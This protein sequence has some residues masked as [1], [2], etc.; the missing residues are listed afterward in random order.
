MKSNNYRN[1][2]YRLLAKY[3]QV[4]HYAKKAKI[5]IIRLHNSY[6]RLKQHY[7]KTLQ[8]AA[9]NTKTLLEQ[10]IKEK[11]PLI[12]DHRRR[13]VYISG[14]LLDAMEMTKEEFASSFYIDL[15]FEKYLPNN[16]TTTDELAI[17]EFHFPI[18]LQDMT[19]LGITTEQTASGSDM[20]LHPFLHLGISGKRVYNKRKKLFYYFLATRDMSA[21]IELL[22]Y[23]KSDFF[24]ETLSA[25]NLQLL[26]A[27]KTIEAHKMM[28][29]SLVCSLVEEH[30]RETSQHLQN[31]RIITTYIIEEIYRLKLITK[32]P[33]ETFQY[34]KDIAYTSVLHDIGK[35]H[36]RKELIEKR[37]DLTEREFKEMQNHTKAGAAYIKKI[38][39]LF[40]HDPSF[41]SY[42]N[43]LK[44]PYDVCL[45]HHERWDGKGYP[46]KLA[47]TDIPLPARIIAIADAYD[48]MRASRSYNIPRSHEEAVAEIRTCSGT[49]FDPTLVKVFLNIE[50]KLEEISY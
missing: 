2:Y 20:Q 23:Q 39:L 3:K 6:V 38:I 15:L 44:I 22:Y 14:K 43:F 4:V 33:Y 37:G 46:M 47:G 30:N 35:V 7:Y 36:I 11:Y 40:Q 17:Q 19:T 41:S 26:H 50:K 28:L 8:K 1:R 13:V 34:L 21:E 42:I 24:I 16:F 45:Y 29:I 10:S 5:L 32:A 48:A 31:I 49:R 12:L 18:M 25:T 9:Y 27:Q